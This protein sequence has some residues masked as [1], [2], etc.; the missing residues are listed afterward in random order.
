MASYFYLM[1]GLPMLKANGEM[2]IKYDEFLSCCEKNVSASKYDLLK[3]LSVNST[4][5][6]LVKEWAE[7]YRKFNDE[8]AFQRN[9][10][11]GHQQNQYFDKDDDASKVISVAI[12]DN[13]PLNAELTLL[14]FLFNKLD[15]LIGTHVFDDYA[16]FGY[17]LKL[18]L[19]ERKTVFNTEIGKSELDRLVKKIEEQIAKI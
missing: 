3:E 15:D 18:K 2:P 16:L 10:K 8:L 9:K 1:S 6:P 7:F 5:G 17:A 13:N 4:Q 11:L 14:S 12:S 19:L